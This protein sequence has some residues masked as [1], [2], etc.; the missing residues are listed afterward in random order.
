M[1]IPLE[2]EQLECGGFRTPATSAC[3]T[4]PRAASIRKTFTEAD[5]LPNWRLL[6]LERATTCT[7]EISYD[8]AII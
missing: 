3:G 1:A 6:Q 2:R 8:G 4:L 5:L 7:L